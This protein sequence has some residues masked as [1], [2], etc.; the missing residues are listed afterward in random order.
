MLYLLHMPD[1]QYPRWFRSIA[2][3]KKARRE[4]AKTMKSDGRNTLSITRIELEKMPLQRLL[5]RIL[6]R[7]RPCE[8]PDLLRKRL[9]DIVKSHEV[10]AGPWTVDA[11]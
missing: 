2:E 4:A 1:N 7:T 8:Q 5:T 11:V 10:I 9:G 3:A 6:N